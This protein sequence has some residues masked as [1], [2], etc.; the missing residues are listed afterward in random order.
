MFHITI[1]FEIPSITTPERHSALAALAVCLCLCLT[2]AAFFSLR[3]SF[4]RL[5][6]S[7]RMKASRHSSLPQRNGVWIVVRGIQARSS[8]SRAIPTIERCIPASQGLPQGFPSG[9][10]VKTKRATPHSSTMSRAEPITTVGM[11]FSSRCRATRLTVWWQTGQRAERRTAST[12]SSR[13]HFKSCGASRRWSCPGCN[14]WALRRSGGK[15]TRCGLRRRIRPGG[16]AAGNYRDRQCGLPF[17]PR[18]DG[19]YRGG[20]RRGF[21]AIA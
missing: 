7:T 9:K 19:P 14:P 18:Q 6:S 20:R 13:H 12:P 15:P 4:S 8:R 17:Y 5:L 16:S 11:P 10:S 2:A 21:I 1:I 3:A